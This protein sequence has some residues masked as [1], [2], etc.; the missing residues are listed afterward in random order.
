MKTMDVRLLLAALLLPLFSLTGCKPNPPLSTD[1][2]VPPD[3]PS[4][5]R[6]DPAAAKPPVHKED[7]LAKSLDR[8]VTLEGV[9][10]ETGEFGAAIKGAN[11]YAFVGGLPRWPESAGGEMVKARGVLRKKFFIN[12]P[13][14]NSY[15]GVTGSGKESHYTLENCRWEVLP[16]TGPFAD[17][18]GQKVSLVGVCQPGKAWPRLV[19]EG[20]GLGVTGISGWPQELIGKKVEITG[21]LKRYKASGPLLVRLRGGEWM[22]SQGAYGSEYLLEGVAWKV[23]PEPVR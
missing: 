19:G 18:V 4:Q 10:I 1:A 22:D 14:P 21:T 16:L 3:A 12:G 23:L 5:P 6:T 9:A 2:A 11:F 7:V 17:K 8:E 13:E 20:F 15:Y